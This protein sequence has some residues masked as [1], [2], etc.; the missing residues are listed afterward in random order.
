MKLLLIIS[1]LFLLASCGMTQEE[2]A[3]ATADAVLLCAS[4]NLWYQYMITW[5]WVVVEC[6]PING[7]APVNTPMIDAYTPE[8]F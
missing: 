6:I 4:Y 2:K 1:S 7:T 8:N 5:Q 3:K